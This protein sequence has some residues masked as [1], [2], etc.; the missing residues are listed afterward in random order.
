M[1]YKHNTVLQITDENMNNL[2]SDIEPYIN[3]HD[4]NLIYICPSD[5]N[6]NEIFVETFDGENDNFK[7]DEKIILKYKNN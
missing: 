4:L 6:K 1:K 5:F 7:N 3:G 2:T